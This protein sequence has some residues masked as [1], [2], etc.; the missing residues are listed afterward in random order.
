MKNNRLLLQ[1][2]SILVPISIYYFKPPTNYILILVLIQGWLCLYYG[3]HLINR[4]RN[5]KFGNLFLTKLFHPSYG[6]EPDNDDKNSKGINLR[7][8]GILMILAGLLQIFIYLMYLRD[9]N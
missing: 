1:T 9:I 7:R 6:I 4:S 8:F 5:E 2:L 3:I